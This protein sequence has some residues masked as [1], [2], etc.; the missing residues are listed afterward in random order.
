MASKGIRRG[1]LR[2]LEGG[3]PGSLSLAQSFLKAN[4][5]DEYRIQVRPT[6]AG[7][8]R[9]LF[10]ILDAYENLKLVDFRRRDTG[11]MFLHHERVSEEGP[12]RGRDI[13]A[14]PDG[15]GLKDP[16]I[17]VEVKHREGKTGSQAIRSFTGGLIPLRKIYWPIKVE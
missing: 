16:R 17:I 12:D 10:G 5:I 4:L 13:A 3:S 9:P 2:H 6:L 8:G 15:L 1:R 7:G 11:V 14:S